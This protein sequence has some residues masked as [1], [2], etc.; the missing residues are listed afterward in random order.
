MSLSDAF[1][2]ETERGNAMLEFNIQSIVQSIQCWRA[3]RDVVAEATNFIVSVSDHEEQCKTMFRSG[4]VWRFSDSILAIIASGSNA[5]VRRVVIVNYCRG[6]TFVTFSC[7]RL[8]SC[9]SL[10]C[11]EWRHLRLLRPT[12]NGKPVVVK[13]IND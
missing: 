7:L 12:W 11:V 9:S 8:S 5:N 3:E 6:Q 4:L 10:H 13:L 2:E 1:S